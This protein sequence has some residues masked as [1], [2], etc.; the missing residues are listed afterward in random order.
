MCFPDFDAISITSKCENDWE[1]K[2]QAKYK[3]KDQFVVFV[4]SP[5][6]A[7]KTYLMEAIIARES[8]ER[9]C[10]R[11]DCSNDELVERAMELVL[12]S[13]FPDDSKALLVADEFHMLSEEHKTQLI[14]W[15]ASR[16]SWLKV[17]IIA[18]RSNGKCLHLYLLK[19]LLN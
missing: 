6:G 16:L 19:M 8:E 13:H 18:N 11:V 7:G 12:K 3:L 14:Y 4:E 5:P 1:D 9:R 2:L 15:I 17:F 10:E